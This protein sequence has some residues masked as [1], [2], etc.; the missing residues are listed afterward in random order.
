MIEL[1]SDLKGTVISIDGKDP[2]IPHAFFYAVNCPDKLLC[3]G[4]CNHVQF[5]G[6]SLQD[7][8]D[9]NSESIEKDTFSTSEPN[10]IKNLTEF[11]EL[12]EENHFKLNKDLFLEYFK[13]ETE[14]ENTF[15]K[16]FSIDEAQSQIDKLPECIKLI[17]Y[18]E[19]PDYL[20][21]EL[22]P[23]LT[24][25]KILTHCEIS[26]KLSF[27][28]I[29]KCSKTIVLLCRA[30]YN[31]TIENIDILIFTFPEI[32]K[33]I[34]AK[35]VVHESFEHLDESNEEE[36]QFIA[37]KQND[38]FCASSLE[39]KLYFQLY[40]ENDS[41]LEEHFEKFKEIERLN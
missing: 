35:L 7:F 26:S 1:V 32:N 29:I 10:L 33:L 28:D 25:E 30:I 21:E 41:R 14:M 20:K 17:P 18:E 39:A 36:T 31:T 2:V 4:L 34:F 40:E 22:E 12:V 9:E 6:Y 11:L 5:G 16:V 13:R 19:P 38:Y 24:I 23:G 37:T 27:E 15:C 3:K 8:F